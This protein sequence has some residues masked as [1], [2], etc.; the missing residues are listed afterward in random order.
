MEMNGWPVPSVDARVRNMI[1]GNAG[2][3]IWITWII[4]QA[5]PLISDFLTSGLVLTNYNPSFLNE[6]DQYRS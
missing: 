1:I 4:K 3:V 6:R 5:L 2:G